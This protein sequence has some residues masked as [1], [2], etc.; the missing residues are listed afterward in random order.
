MGGIEVAAAVVSVVEMPGLARFDQLAAAAAA[1]ANRD[2][3]TPNMP[4]SSDYV[5]PDVA[6]EAPGHRV[7]GPGRKNDPERD[8]HLNR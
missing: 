5:R 8:V 1:P 2:R 6:A 7:Q 4:L 3:R